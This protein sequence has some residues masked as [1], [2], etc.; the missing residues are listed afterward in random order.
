MYLTSSHLNRALA[1]KSNLNYTCTLHPKL[2]TRKSGK[3]KAASKPSMSTARNRLDP[4]P[5]TPKKLN[6]KVSAKHYR[7]ALSSQGIGHLPAKESAF[8][9]SA[10]HLQAKGFTGSTFWSS[11]LQS[12]ERFQ[13]AGRRVWNADWPRSCQ[14]ARLLLAMLALKHSRLKDNNCKGARCFSS[15]GWGL[16]TKAVM[17]GNSAFSP[18]LKNPEQPIFSFRFGTQGVVLPAARP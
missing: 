15:L 8:R 11:R 12:I 10:R 13:S 14:Q 7:Q 2:C 3:G 9:P 18:V 4:H 17:I 1:K 6:T 16:M 5:P